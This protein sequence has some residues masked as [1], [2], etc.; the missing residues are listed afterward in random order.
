MTRIKNRK[1]RQTAQRAVALGA[2]AAR[3]SHS[4]ARCGSAEA[5]INYL[6]QF[7]HL[8]STSKTTTAF[9]L[10]SVATLVLISRL[11][12]F[13]LVSRT[14]ITAIKTAVRCS[15]TYQALLRQMLFS[16]HRRALSDCHLHS[17]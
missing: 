2:G 10:I 13:G 14:W 1:S 6:P 9:A 8:R 7:V 17:L 15:C 4:S 12:V 16:S 3:R 11:A 5:W